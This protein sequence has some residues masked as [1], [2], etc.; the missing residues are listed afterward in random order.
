[1]VAIGGTVGV[2][3]GALVIIEILI[4][5]PGLGIAIAGRIAGALAGAGAGGATGAIVGALIKAGLSNSVATEYK[6]AMN[7]GHIIISVEPK[8]RHDIVL[9][10]SYGKEIY[11]DYAI[12]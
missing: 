7:K 5:I 3:A 2:I 11:N 10:E 8:D 12:K 1:M 6:N 4:V 9:S